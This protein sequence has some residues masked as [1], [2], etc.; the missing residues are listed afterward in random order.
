MEVT[1]SG[2]RRAY[3]S[4]WLVN[5][6]GEGSPGHLLPQVQ[7]SDNGSLDRITQKKINWALERCFEIRPEKR[8]TAEE[9]LGTF[10]SRASVDIRHSEVYK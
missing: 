3:E 9:L 10:Y 6:Y 8:A 2:K 5:K 7:N 4:D 1:T